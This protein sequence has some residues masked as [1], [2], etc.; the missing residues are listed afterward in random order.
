MQIAQII[1]GYTLGGADLLRRAMGKKK[2][3]EMAKH[4]DI[5]VAGALKRNYDEKLANQLFDLM[6]MFAE[7]GFNKSHT[8]AYAVVT[9]QTAW[10]KAHYPS[11]FYAGTLSSDM[12]DTDKV[13]LFVRDAI[14]NKVEILPPDI[15]ESLW[16]F[17]A[18]GDRTVRYGLGAIKG[19]GEAAIAS[20]VNERQNGPYVDL[21]DFCRRV[22]RRLM[23]KRSLEAL[24]RAG[25]FD[26]LEDNRARL[27][28]NVGPAMEL[29]EVAA[30]S[31]N[32][33]SLFG[34]E[35]ENGADAPVWR[36]VPPF[37]ERQRLQEEK[38]ALGFFL[39]GHLFHGYAKEVRRFASTRL[40]TLAPQQ[41]TLLLA[42]IVT[43]VRVQN[44]RRGKMVFVTLDDS[45]GSVDIAIYSELVEQHRRIIR[46]DELLVIS[47]KVSR[48]DYSGGMRVVA[49][50]VLDLA[51]AR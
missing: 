31:V 18:V 17:K 11:E 39:S 6:A 50:K 24:I 15:N 38:A 34:G 41:Q 3:E 44:T 46:E 22:D 5:F 26:R 8:A 10:L 49:D 42:G 13:K 28:A 2:A 35:E 9:Y 45:T 12:N 21:F 40:G 32:Q 16:S 48:D 51:A 30:A 14:D 4:R 1:G 27:L 47:A 23:N 19:A 25:A 37:T 20:A 7:Y 43:E 33:V 36:D 29:A